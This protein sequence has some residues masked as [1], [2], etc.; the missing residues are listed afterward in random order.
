VMDG[1]EVLEELRADGALASLPVVVLTTSSAEKDVQA[2]YRLRCSSYIVKPLSF[3]QFHGVIR[4]ITQYW[5]SVVK[6]PNGRWAHG[7]A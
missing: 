2:A 1:R 5:F 4:S 3:D 7:A 6:L